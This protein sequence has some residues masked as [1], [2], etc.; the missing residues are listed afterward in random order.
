MLDSRPVDEAN[1]IKRRREC[2][3][4]GRR[5]T[6]YE[7]IE[8]VPVMVIKKDGSREYFDRHKLR[9]GL[10]SACRKRPVDVDAVVATVEQEINGMLLSEISSR[11]IGAIVLEQLR[12]VDKVSYIRFASVYR[13]FQDVDSFLEELRKIKPRG[14]KD[15]Q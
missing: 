9:A 5:F 13:E 11:E 15:K 2:V 6:T 1:S 3:Q 4:C 8:S 7:M 10:L 14:K 12:A